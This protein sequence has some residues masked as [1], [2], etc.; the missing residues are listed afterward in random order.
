[1]FLHL[2][3][4]VCACIYVRVRC[5]VAAAVMSL[6]YRGGMG[7]ARAR[8]F[9]PYPEESLEDVPALSGG[10]GDRGGSGPIYRIDMNRG[11]TGVPARSPT[12]N[13]TRPLKDPHRARL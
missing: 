6:G 5:L 11:A 9:P 8:T 7:A 2:V 13:T 1:M 10:I 3:W 12:V 4:S